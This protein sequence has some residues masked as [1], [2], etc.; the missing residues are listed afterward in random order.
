MLALLPR[1]TRRY[2]GLGLQVAQATGDTDPVSTPGQLPP[3]IERA[4]LLVTTPE[5]LDSLTRTPDYE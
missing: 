2:K 5:K 4:Q 1:R 3:E